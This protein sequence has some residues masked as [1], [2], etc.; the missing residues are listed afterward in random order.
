M[1]TDIRDAYLLWQHTGTPGDEAE[2]LLECLRAGRICKLRLQAAAE[3]GH[4]ASRIVL[5]L[6]DDGSENAEWPRALAMVGREACVMA[7][8]VVTREIAQSV[9]GEDIPELVGEIVRL[10]SEWLE[11]DNGRDELEQQARRL[12]R[13]CF[14]TR[15]E[16][17][18]YLVFEA[19]SILGLFMYAPLEQPVDSLLS[20]IREQRIPVFSTIRTAVSRELVSWLVHRHAE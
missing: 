4:Q 11:A 10:S 18:E 3:L 20:L 1:D 16:G 12:A 6:T 15:L 13:H 19:A 7:G 14:D 8:A 17:D 2:W 9:F 5:N